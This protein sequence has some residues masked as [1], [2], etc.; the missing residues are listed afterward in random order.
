MDIVKKNI[1]SIIFGVIAIAAVV[2]NFYPMGGKRQQLKEEAG[3]HAAKAEELKNLMDKPRKLPVVQPGSTE[4]T[5]LPGFPTHQALDAAKAATEQV[6]KAADTLMDKTSGDLNRHTP[7]VQGALPGE[8]GNTL[9]ASS[10]ARAYV[11][12]FPIQAQPGAI[13]VTSTPATRPAGSPPSLIELLHAG[14]PPT[15]AELQTARADK[16]DQVQKEIT[17]YTATGQVTNPDEVQQAVLA[18]VKEVGETMRSTRAKA[19]K[20]W[21]DP[22]AF[23]MYPGMTVGAVP[24]PTDIFWSQ[25][26]LW[27]Q[28]DVCKGIADTNAS[29]T[30]VLDAP[31]KMLVKVSFVNSNQPGSQAQPSPVPV[32]VFPNLQPSSGVTAGGNPMEMPGAAPSDPNATPQAPLDPNAPLDKKTAYSPTGRISNGLFDVVHFDL[33][34]IVDAAKV[35][36]VLES[37]GANRYITVTQLQSLDTIDSAYYRGAGYHFGAK[38]CV[39]LKVRCEE[40]FFRKWLAD[41]VPARLKPVLG[42]QPPAPPPAQP[43]A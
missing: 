4:E 15:D 8:P 17:R 40:L 2:A 14:I 31:V 5:P 38:P 1:V 12:M 22:A 27:V 24:G 41:F 25:I 39:H 32:F 21:V 7:L 42:Y 9:P 28:E 43:P 16:Q 20:V 23:S 34:L 18:A 3:Q 36:F 11:G 33:E 10:F 30:S 6:N 37:I 35:P 19:C 13:A 29:A 26:G